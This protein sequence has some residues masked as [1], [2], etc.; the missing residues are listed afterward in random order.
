MFFH[1]FPK[2]GDIKKGLTLPRERGRIPP[3]GTT[4]GSKTKKRRSRVG[5]PQDG[6]P[7]YL[8]NRFLKKAMMVRKKRMMR[9]P[10][11]AASTVSSSVYS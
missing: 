5:T 2:N 3:R 7:D 1:C 6:S 8:L 4:A 9:A 11:P 10:M